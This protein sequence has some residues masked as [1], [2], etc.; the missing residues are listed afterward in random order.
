MFCLYAG[1]SA[2]LASPPY[3]LNYVAPLQTA[4]RYWAS[5]AIFQLVSLLPLTAGT[6]KSACAPFLK[7]LSYILKSIYATFV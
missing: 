5:E 7:N 4:W 6:G 1:D 3:V 2:I